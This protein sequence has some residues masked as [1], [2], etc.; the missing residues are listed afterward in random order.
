ME[1]CIRQ[2]NAIDIYEE[3]FADSSDSATSRVPS[4]KSINV[5]RYIFYKLVIQML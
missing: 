5:F 2:N 4:A 1:H 3:Y